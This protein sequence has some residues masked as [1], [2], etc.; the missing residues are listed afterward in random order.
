MR[1]CWN[2]AILKTTQSL[3]NWIESQGQD[4]TK[5]KQ[6]WGRRFLWDCVF[7]KLLSVGNTLFIFINFIALVCTCRCYTHNIRHT[8]WPELLPHTGVIP[9]FYTSFLCLTS[10]GSSSPKSD[11][12]RT[13]QTDSLKIHSRVSGTVNWHWFERSHI[14]SSLLNGLLMTSKPP[15]CIVTI[16]SGKDTANESLLFNVVEPTVQAWSIPREEGWTK[17]SLLPC[18]TLDATGYLESK[19]A[20]RLATVVCCETIQV[21]LGVRQLPWFISISFEDKDWVSVVASLCCGD[22][23]FFLLAF[24]SEVTAHKEKLLFLVRG[25]GCNGSMPN[26]VALLF[27]KCW[28]KSERAFPVTCSCSEP[29]LLHQVDTRTQH[30]VC[31]RQL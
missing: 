16:W 4:S 18:L 20:L 22:V 14:P 5:D 8:P 21:C 27:E 24:Y 17:L 29:I 15:T 19:S 28:R 26:G 30:D 1:S 6:A 9:I 10:P 31:S 12:A 13:K 2:W 7:I 3:T 25:S 23:H 11:P